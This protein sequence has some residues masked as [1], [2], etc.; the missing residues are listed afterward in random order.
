MKNKNLII[1]S[2][3]NAKNETKINELVSII[4]YNNNS[5]TKNFD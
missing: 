5:K 1:L 2:E 3:N 4:E